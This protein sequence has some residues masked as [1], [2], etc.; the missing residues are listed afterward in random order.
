MRNNLASE[1]K[2]AALAIPAALVLAVLSLLLTPARAED[3]AKPACEMPS[4]MLATEM[5]LPK[6]AD[7]VKSSHKLDITVVGSGSSTLAGPDGASAAYPARLEYYLGQKLSGIT[8]HIATDLHMRQSAEDVAQGLGKLV[9]DGKPSL[10]IWQTGT[11]DALRSIDPDD[12][13][14]ALGEGIAALKEAGADVVLM[15]PQYNPRMETVL[16][17]NTYLDNIRVAAQEKDVPLFDRFSLMRQWSDAGDFD[18]SVTTR[19]QTQARSVHDCLGRALADFVVAAAHLGPEQPQDPN[20]DS[21]KDS[22]KDQK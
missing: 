5:V 15:N 2:R 11:V 8:V 3:P 10:V 20:K 18:F 14:G 21:N 4:D 22:T 1:R 6:A 9:K 17:V 19:S 7:E 12:F 16:S 13:R